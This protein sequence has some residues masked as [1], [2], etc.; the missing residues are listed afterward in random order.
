VS[1]NYPSPESWNRPRSHPEWRRGLRKGWWTRTWQRFTGPFRRTWVAGPFPPSI[2]MPALLDVHE[3]NEEFSFET[4]AL[5][6]AFNFR[7]RIRCSWTVQA[8]ASD[9]EMEKKIAEV[10]EFIQGSRAITRDRLEERIRPIARAF[11]PYRAA[12]AEETLNQTISDCLNDGDVR[13]T[14]RTWVDVSD[15]VREDLQKVWRERLVAE[16]GVELDGVLRKAHVALLGELQEDWRKLLIAGLAGIGA[17]DEASATWLA[18]YALALAEDPENAA[19]YLKNVL[20]GRVDHAEQLLADLG[21][22]AIDDRVEAI[23]FAFQ[24]Q[25]AL[26]RLLMYLGVPIPAPNGADGGGA[27]V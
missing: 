20:K 16:S 15:P 25:S 7:I 27:N 4:P 10:R 21:A 19:G 3:P 18:P 26:H 12:E 9:E 1:H 5:G 6:D 14:V 11:P 17:V 23:E 24:S 2:K 22:L 8:T 13:V